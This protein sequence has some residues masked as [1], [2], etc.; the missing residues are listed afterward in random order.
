MEQTKKKGTNNMS[1]KNKIPYSI[2]YEIV[3]NERFDLPDHTCTIIDKSI[4]LNEQIRLANQQLREAAQNYARVNSKLVN[5][6]N[7]AHQRIAVVEAQNKELQFTREYIEKLSSGATS[8]N[9]ADVIQM[10][11]RL[12]VLEDVSEILED[13]LSVTGRHY[14]SSSYFK[15]TIQ[16]KTAKYI[17]DSAIERQEVAKRNKEVALSKLT[18]D[19]LSA[20]GLKR[21]DLFIK[22]NNDDYEEEDD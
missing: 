10:T 17:K 9:A 15:T 8:S 3:E 16:P 5:K 1:G 14:S 22:S 18:D 11:I 7:D 12:K 13:V 21:R 2:E 4:Q 6:I 19:D 20:L